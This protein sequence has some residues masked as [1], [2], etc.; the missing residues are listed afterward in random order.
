MLREIIN[1]T[2]SLSEESFVRNL[3]PQ[4]GLHLQIELTDDGKLKNHQCEIFREKDGMSSFLKKCLDLQIHTKCVSSAK[5][6]DAPIKQLRSC[7]PYCIAF[8]AVFL[9][10]Q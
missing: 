10:N 1:F 3:L 6:F 8:E 9:N 7:C 5:R 2:R 4:E